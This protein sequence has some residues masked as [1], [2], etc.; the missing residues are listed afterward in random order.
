V[1]DRIASSLRFR[2]RATPSTGR[3]PSTIRKPPIQL[4]QKVRNVQ[5]TQKRIFLW[6]SSTPS[7]FD[8][9][10][11]IT[12]IRSASLEH[13]M[14]FRWVIIWNLVND[15]EAGKGKIGMPMISSGTNHPPRAPAKSTLVNFS[16]CFLHFRACGVI[17]KLVCR[18]LHGR[19]NWNVLATPIEHV[20]TANYGRCL[21]VRNLV[22]VK[23]GPFPRLTWAILR[24]NKTW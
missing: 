23:Y 8:G 19:G 18:T 16:P 12:V 5:K 14:A 6:R 20:V 22:F 1:Y 17:L 24:W 3:G 11:W 15:K 7:P 9:Y 2:P 4:I 13:S 10:R 21:R